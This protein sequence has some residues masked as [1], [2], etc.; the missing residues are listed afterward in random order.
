MALFQTDAAQIG[1]IAALM[2]SAH[3]GEALNAA[4]MLV[5]RLGGH[6]LRIADVIERGLKPEFEPNCDSAIYSWP[7]RSPQAAPHVAVVDALLAGL[8]FRAECMTHRSASFLGGIRNTPSLTPAQQE[9]LDDLVAKA[10]RLRAAR[11]AA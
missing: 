4:R 2:E 7:R 11:A 9:W 3:D 10:A 8:H 5:K 1:K 6:A